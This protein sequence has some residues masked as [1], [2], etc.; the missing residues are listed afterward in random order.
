MG[1][2]FAA[3]VLA[4]GSAGTHGGLALA[5]AHAMPDAQV[6]GITVSRPVEAQGAQGGRA[7]RRNGGIARHRKYR[8]NCGS[9]LWDEYFLPRYGEPN[10]AAL[11]AVRLLARTEG[12]LLDPC[13]R[14][15]RWLACST[16]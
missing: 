1:V 6:V 16:A 15:K 3:V 9:N 4:S 10:R 5:L 13:I 12:V 2:S 7:D 14:E 11:D 8:R